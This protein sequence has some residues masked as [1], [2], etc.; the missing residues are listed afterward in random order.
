MLNAPAVLDRALADPGSGPWSWRQSILAAQAAAR[1]ERALTKPVISGFVQDPDA[2][3]L[4]YS[5][6]GYSTKTNF[7]FVVVPLRSLRDLEVFRQLTPF[8]NLAIIAD[9]IIAEHLDNIA[10]QV[11]EASAHFTRKS[12]SCRPGITPRK[13]WSSSTRKPTPCISRRRCACRRRNGAR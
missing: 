11:R 7:N 4:P 13:C 3:G 2:A 6:N 10:G 5:T 1:P 12:N 9:G 8:T